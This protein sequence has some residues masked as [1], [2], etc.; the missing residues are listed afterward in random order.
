MKQRLLGQAAVPIAEI[1]LG[2]MGMSEFYGPSDDQQSLAT[3]TRALDIG[4]NFL[5][6]PILMA[7]AIMKICW[8][9]F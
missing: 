2:C 9:S 6:L 7:W 3:L 8:G 1:G 5:I 4:I